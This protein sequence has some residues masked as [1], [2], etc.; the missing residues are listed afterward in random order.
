MRGNALEFAVQ[1]LGGVTTEL[2][3]LGGGD[4]VGVRGHRG[5]WFPMGD[6]KGEDILVLG[7]GIG[8]A[9]MRP[10]LQIILDN[11]D[12]FGKLKIQWAAR[13]PDSL[14]FR[15]EYTT[16]RIMSNTELHFTVKE[17][18]DGWVGEVGLITQLLEKV[19]PIAEN[20]IAITCGPPTMIYHVDKTLQ[21]LG[22]LPEQLYGTLE[23]R[24]R[25][26]ISKCGRCNLGEKL[27][28]VDGPIFSMADVGNL[29][30]NFR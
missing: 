15:D 25:C 24:M 9:P 23:A 28:C 27:I 8:G 5:N 21:K 2:H 16:W 1:R 12:D 6:F 10:V 18:D 7:G 29:L 13:H 14:I 30:E 4:I 3:E 20:T 19:N 22:Y 26:G 11:R 17:A